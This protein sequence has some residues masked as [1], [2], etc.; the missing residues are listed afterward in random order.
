MVKH[1][2]PRPDVETIIYV[3]VLL[4]NLNNVMCNTKKKERKNPRKYLLNNSL[5]LQ[6][7]HSVKTYGNPLEFTLSI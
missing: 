2:S 7:Q 4:P 1:C 3:C 5:T 6:N